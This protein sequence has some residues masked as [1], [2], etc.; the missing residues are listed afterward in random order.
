MRATNRRKTGHTT[1]TDSRER[2]RAATSWLRTPV[3]A[4]LGRLLW[5][6]I[7]AR[8]STDEQNPRSIADQVAYCREFL[9]SLG[10]TNVRIEILSD[11]GISGEIVSRPGIDQVHVGCLE[12]RWNLILA[13][14]G[15]RLYRHE[16]AAGELI[17]TAVDEGIRVICINDF[18]DTAQE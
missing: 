17:E 9:D 14:D 6:L 18:V 15:S 5:V 4:P 12:R 1:R 3:E 8:F 13:E 11:E 10:L 7:Y 16:T 2:G